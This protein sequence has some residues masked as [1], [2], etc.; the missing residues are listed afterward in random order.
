MESLRNPYHKLYFKFINPSIG[1]GVFTD[2]KIEKDQVVEI[3]YCIPANP[4]DV[5]Y[6]NFLFAINYGVEDFLP[7]GF[8]LIYNHSNDPN[9]IWRIEDIKLRVIKFIA[10]KDIEIG[11]E[12]T[13]NYGTRWWNERKNITLI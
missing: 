1:F 6:K 11:D 12:L 10:I 7:T 3:C 9:M 8:G 13:H 4:N 5:Y 2:S